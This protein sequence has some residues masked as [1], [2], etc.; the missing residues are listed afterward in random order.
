VKENREMTIEDLREHLR[1][2]MPY[3]TERI[4]QL[5]DELSELRKKEQEIHKKI[6]D[7]DMECSAL[8]YNLQDLMMIQK[9]LG[10]LEDLIIE[11]IKQ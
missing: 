8:A 5:E 4:G 1:S 11:H 3:L 7:R 2:R 9:S 10:Q 6:K